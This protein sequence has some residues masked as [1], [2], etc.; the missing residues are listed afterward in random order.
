MFGKHINILVIIF[1]L[2]LGITHAKEKNYSNVILD[3]DINYRVYT[4]F[5]SSSREILAFGVA[6]DMIQAKSQLKSLD[7]VGV[8]NIE[9]E[10]DNDLGSF[11]KK[12]FEVLEKISSYKLYNDGIPPLY[13]PE[14]ALLILAKDYK[15]IT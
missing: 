14:P 3:H 13:Q 9:I 10:F 6:V 11:A 8:T 1:L 4:V 12:L 7:E 5:E 15:L 2:T